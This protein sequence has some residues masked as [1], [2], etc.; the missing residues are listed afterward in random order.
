MTRNFCTVLLE[1][2]SILEP[3]AIYL[4]VLIVEMFI[5]KN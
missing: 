1:D 4:E 2:H 5:L 3:D